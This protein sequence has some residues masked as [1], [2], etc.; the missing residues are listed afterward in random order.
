MSYTAK[1][2]CKSMVTIPVKMM[3]K[4]GV[5]EG[6]KVKFIEGKTGILMI[7]IPKLEDLRGID[8]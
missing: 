7:S 6:M 4:Y 1:V 5:K 8:R 2:T 3:R